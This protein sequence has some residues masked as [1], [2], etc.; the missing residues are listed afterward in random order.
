[1]RHGFFNLELEY[2]IKFRAQTRPRKEGDFWGNPQVKL[3]TNQTNMMWKPALL[4][5]TCGRN[6]L[7]PDM[8]Y[9]LCYCEQAVT[10][11]FVNRGA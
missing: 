8:E 6:S 1:M 5:L 2:F 7:F 11:A 10:E 4:K 3:C 9:L